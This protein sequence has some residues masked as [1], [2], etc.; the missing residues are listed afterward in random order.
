MCVFIIFDTKRL[1][2]STSFM[3]FINYCYGWSVVVYCLRESFI[4]QSNL[5]DGTELYRQTFTGCSG[6][7]VCVY[8]YMCVCVYVCMCACV[9]VYVCMCVRV[10]MCVCVCVCAC[11]RMCMCVHIRF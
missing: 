5:Q 7:Y 10:Y 8:V 4:F 11:V 1:L 9:R 3:N 2:S 6:M